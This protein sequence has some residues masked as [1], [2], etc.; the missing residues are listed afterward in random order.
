VTKTILV[1]DDQADN[2]ELFRYLL[3]RAGHQV[4]TA[5]GGKEGLER[6]EEL[7]PDLVIIDLQMPDIDGWELAR[8]IRQDD[9]LADTRLLAMSVGPQTEEGAR[10]PGFDGFFAMPFEPADL[11]GVVDTILGSGP[12][13]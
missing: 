12:A 6:A 13:G 2:L 10:E 11:A 1:V 8:R 7:R 9:K 4:V 5:Q 3:D